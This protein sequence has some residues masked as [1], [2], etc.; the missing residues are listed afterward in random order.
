MIVGMHAVIKEARATLVLA[1][2]MIIGQMSQVLM[3]V[4]DTVMIGRVGT[5]PLAAS[6]FGSSVFNVLFI[7]GIG[8][9]VPVSVFASRS[10]GA[11]RHDE[12]GEYL[13][14]GLL[15]AFLAC[16]IELVAIG[17]MSRHLGSFGQA[18][19]VVAS[20]NPF[21]LLIGVSLVPVFGY[22]A[23]R[24]FAESMGRPWVPTVIILSTV[25]LNVV[26]NWAFIFGHLGSPEMGLTGSGL[27]TLIARTLSCV[28]IFIW[29]RS[30]PAM[31]G[32]WPT[33]WLAPFS[34]ERI[35]RML[36]VGMPAAGCLLFEIGAFA[37]ATVMMGWLGAVS[38]AAHQVAISCAGLTFMVA[39]GI[40]MAVGIR[41]SAAVGAGDHGRLRTIWLGGS[42]MAASM[43]LVLT[44][45]FILWGHSIASLFIADPAVISVAT[46]LL[47]VAGIFQL[48][49]GNQVINA[50]ALRGMTDVR[51]PAAMT[52]VA[53]W[54]VAL[55]LA[56]LFGIHWGYGPVGMWTALALGLAVAS[57]LLGYRFLRLTRPAAT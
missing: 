21:F 44:F 51:I 55:P 23:M 2:P 43:A 56:Y 53:Y 46:R 31:K 7:I 16:I 14:H 42:G 36:H 19:E 3:G 15:L 52:F 26:L 33:R 41:T 27:A 39:L 12:A 32:A 4:T 25:A 57:F 47:V 11:G 20:A 22:S 5:V 17:I 54:V 6:A 38:L 45:V 18:P 34:R 24:Q 10:R 28:I 48:F 9:L 30:D 50:A 13:R 49:D 1:V 35:W 40:S 8:L 29:L 37:A